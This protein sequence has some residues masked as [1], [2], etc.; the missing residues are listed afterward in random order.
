MEVRV[1]PEPF[2]YNLED[3]ANCSVNPTYMDDNPIKVLLYHKSPSLAKV[4]GQFLC[5]NEK[6]VN[7]QEIY[8]TQKSKVLQFVKYIFPAY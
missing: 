2:D 5:L 6:K 8:L 7:K 1:S 4:I 3:V